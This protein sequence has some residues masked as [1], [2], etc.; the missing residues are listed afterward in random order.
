MGRRSVTKLNFKLKDR[1]RRALR[2]KPDRL[3][4]LYNMQ[5][6]NDLSKHTRRV[7]VARANSSARLANLFGIIIKAIKGLAKLPERARILWA[8]K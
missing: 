5:V 7:R 1:R 4:S 2:R 6:L 3:I 8:I